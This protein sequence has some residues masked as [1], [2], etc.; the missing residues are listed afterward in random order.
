MLE[1]LESNRPGPRQLQGVELS[2]ESHHL[3]EFS[4]D[5][6]LPD[7]DICY[8][9][10]S[11]ILQL[12]SHDSTKRTAPARPAFVLQSRPGWAAEH[13]DDPPAVWAGALLAAAVELCGDWVTRPSWVDTRRWRFARL[14][15]GD[16]L[17]APLLVRLGNGACI[18]IAGEA[19]AEG[20]GV[21]AAWL[22][23]R[24]LADRLRREG[25]A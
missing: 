3:N 6:P 18:G 20:G 11:D 4:L 7:W 1:V 17:T 2:Y 14:A 9:R 8:P 15:G 24:R 23:G 10:E 16:A 19:L 13:W 5:T 25:Q 21:Q 12:I 22:S